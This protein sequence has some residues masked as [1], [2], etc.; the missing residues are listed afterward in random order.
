MFIRKTLAYTR[1]C[2]GCGATFKSIRDDQLRCE[3]DCGRV[4]TSESRNGARSEAR[5]NY[6][7][8]FIGVDGEGVTHADGSHSYVLLSVGERSLHRDG[9]HLTFAEILEFLWECY[10]ENPEAVYV[11]YYLKYDFN[12]WLRSMPQDRAEILL[13]PSKRARTKSGNNTTP[14][15]VLFG[16]EWEF[17]LLAF[18][19]FKLRKVGEKNW[20]YISDVGGFFQQSFVASMSDKWQDKH[21]A[22]I[23]VVTD[24]ERE[25][26]ERGKARR[27]DA[28]FDKEMMR[29]NCAEN[30]VLSRMMRVLAEGFKEMG[31]NLRRQEWFGPG[32][33]AQ[34]WLDETSNH[35]TKVLNAKAENDELF[36]SVMEAARATYYGGWFETTAHGHIG[37]T[38][39]YDIS[40]AYPHIISQLPCLL[41]GEWVHHK[42]GEVDAASYPWAL[43]RA[44]VRGSNPYLG[45]MLHR[46]KN[47]RIN[48]P[49]YTSGWYWSHE[50][51]SAKNAGLICEIQTHEMYG[52]KPCACPPPLRDLRASFETRN[53]V[54][55][56]TPYGRCIKL[57]DNSVYGKQAQ[58]VGNPKHAN[59]IFASLTT[60]GTRSM[61][62]DAI[63]S[64]PTGAASVRMIAT[65][66]IYFGERHPGLADQKV[67]LGNWEEQLKKNLTIFLPGVYWDD[68]ARDNR[69]AQVLKVKSRG[70]SARDLIT[71]LDALDDAFCNMRDKE[72]PWR[73]FEGDVD[74]AW[75]CKMDLPIGFSMV[76]ASQALQRGKWDLAGTVTQGG[77]RE[78]WSHPRVKRELVI[79]PTSE[80]PFIS[81]TPPRNP[82][83][84]ASTPYSKE[85]GMKWEREFGEEFVTPDGDHG[86]G[87]AIEV[88]RG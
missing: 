80:R 35:S 40:S 9:A 78:V 10:L 25:I 76:T 50:L 67:A 6:I 44:T 45:A 83:R 5:A 74:P 54:G 70:V 47:G 71:K 4:R 56:K 11:G 20:L 18:K 57:K 27:A 55:K 81:T 7:P 59:P 43:C 63:A 73:M 65:D 30:R 38:F 15:P 82:T 69:E 19:R 2:V 12:Q 42:D 75:W 68:S 16:D 51:R 8:E 66:G 86:D 29:Y 14:F 26:I 24:A 60:A 58:S 28:K 13:T 41:H 32:Q 84:E 85:F 79:A 52:Y 88:L 61:I 39:E 1:E 64:H 34:K 46:D 21:G 3:A 72:I 23:E 17:D 22:P 36:K 33:V 49:L 87:A 62:C 37:D 48:R 77:T 53:A 31:I